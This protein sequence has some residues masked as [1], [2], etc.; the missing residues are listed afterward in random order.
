MADTKKKSCSLCELP[1]LAKGLCKK[2]YYRARAEQERTTPKRVVMTEEERKAAQREANRRYRLKHPV[3]GAARSKKWKEEHP[4][5]KKVRAAR[6]LEYAAKNLERE[7]E[8]TRKWR[9]E[10]PDRAAAGKRDYYAR[11]ADV[12]KQK[13][14][15]YRKEN[16]EMYREYSRQY[17][18]SRRAGGGRLSRGYVQRMMD[19]QN[20]LC[21]ACKCDLRISGHHIDHIK[22]LSK[23]GKHCDENVQLLCPTCNRRKSASEFSD[24]MKKMEAERVQV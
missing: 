21:V 3:V 8:R 12:I 19:S 17:K 2:H 18:S 16:L 23:G 9:A 5:Y 10:H 11:N 14:T 24:F 22:A 6:Q 15:A 4:E 7:R 1:M 13:V 20:G